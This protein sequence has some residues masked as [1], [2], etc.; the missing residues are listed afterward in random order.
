M[1]IGITIG[2]VLMVI[3]LLVTLFNS[4]QQQQIKVRV[5]ELKVWILEELQHYV[6]REL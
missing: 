5:L 6:R 2:D 1:N 3:V 4:W